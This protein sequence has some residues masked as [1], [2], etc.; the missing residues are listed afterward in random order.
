MSEEKPEEKIEL[1]ACM[2]KMY[3]EPHCP[4]VMKQKG[5]PR[6]EEWKAEQNRREEAIKKALPGIFGWQV[7][8]G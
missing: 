8:G 4:C 3:D 1:C 5:L 2:G 7:N 6:S